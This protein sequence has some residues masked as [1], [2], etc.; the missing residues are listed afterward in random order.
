MRKFWRIGAPWS[1]GVWALLVDSFASNLGFFLLIP[2]LAVHLTTHLGWAPWAAG[3]VLALR[4]FSQQGLA[5]VGGALGDRIGYRAA[6]VWGMEVRALGFLLFAVA[7][8]GPM[9][10]LAALLSGIGGALFGPADAAALAAA[11]APEQR[12]QIFSQRVVFGNAGMIL[13]P[14]V[15]AYLVTTSFSLVAFMAGLLFMLAGIFTAIYYPAAAVAPRRTNQQKT[16]WDH[17]FKNR[18]FVHLTAVLSGYYLVSS[19]I[20][21]LLPLVIVFS[22]GNPSLIGWLLALYSGTAI[23]F[24]TTVTRITE[25]I[26][27]KR[28]LVFGLVAGGLGMAVGS[29]FQVSLWL[30]VPSM[31]FLSVASMFINP[32][33]FSAT[34]RLADPEAFGLFYGFSRLSLGLGGSLGN[35]LGGLLFS[36]GVGLSFMALPWISLGVIG[37]ASAIAM[38]RVSLEASESPRVRSPQEHPV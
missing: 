38:S 36:W 13:G 26:G 9:I 21:I 24:Q 32:A 12:G 25:P 6:V 2:V 16:Q 31:L 14:V 28:Q 22:H 15:G 7:H 33:M 27:V 1:A 5:P 19:Q 35:A 17:V 23:L 11:V 10:V 8:S 20:Y 3:L 34:A 30:L 4:Q 18:P 29:L 37:L